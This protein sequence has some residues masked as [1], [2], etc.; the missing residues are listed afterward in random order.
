M[1]FTQDN[2]QLLKAK[3]NAYLD[4]DI[5]LIV[6]LSQFW[7]EERNIYTLIGHE[8]EFFEAHIRSCLYL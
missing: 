5:S 8:K 1:V 3:K 7:T 4:N 6:E 2:S